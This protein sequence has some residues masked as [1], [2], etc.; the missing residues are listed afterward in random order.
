[1]AKIIVGGF[2]T[3]YVE[4]LYNEKQYYVYEPKRNGLTNKELRSNRIC[5]IKYILNSTT[6]LEK[7]I[8]SKNFLKVNKDYFSGIKIKQLDTI[9][10]SIL[11]D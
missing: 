7:N 9:L 11:N 6:L 10:E 2:S 3:S 1:M 8:K 5:N 4:G